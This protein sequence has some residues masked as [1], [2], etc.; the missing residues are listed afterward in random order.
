[1]R[2]ATN[3]LQQERFFRKS[4]YEMEAASGREGGV[5]L[6]EVKKF[7]Q[8]ISYKVTTSALKDRFVR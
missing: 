4:F 5:G 8:R 3:R 1:M 6:S 2:R 7:M